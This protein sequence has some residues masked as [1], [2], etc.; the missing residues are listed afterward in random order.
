MRPQK[1]VILVNEADLKDES[2]IV[3]TH[4]NMPPGEI[5]L[6]DE[7]HYRPELEIPAKEI[8]NMYHPKA[9]RIQF[10]KANRVEAGGKDRRHENS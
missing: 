6:I 3:T 1:I 9:I 4:P 10:D 2:L 8:F 5:R 7:L